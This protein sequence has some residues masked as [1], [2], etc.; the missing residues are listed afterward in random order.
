M[1][2]IINNDMYENTTYSMAQGKPVIYV[3]HNDAGSM[4]ARDYV[5]WLRSAR[6]PD[7][8]KAESGFAHYYVDRNT[9]ARVQNTT[10]VA[11]AMGNTWGNNNALSYEV[12]QQFSA[13]TKEFIENEN[14]VL[15]QMAEDMKFYGD[16]PNHSTIRLHNEYTSTSCPQRTKQLHGNNYETI[17][18]IIDKIKYYQKLGDTVA[19]MLE[20]EGSGVEVNAP[21]PKPAQAKKE[22]DSKETG[23]VLHLPASADRWKIYNANG[24]YTSGD[25]IHQLTPSAYG[26]LEYDVLGNPAPHV[27]LIETGVKGEV[28]IYAHPSTGAWLTGGN[29]PETQTKAVPDSKGGSY[30]HLPASADTWNIY[31]KGGPYTTGNEIHKLTPSAYGG[32]DYEIQGNPAPHVYLIDTDVKGRV[33]IYAHPSTGAT[34]SEN[35]GS[36][37]S[38]KSTAT[39]AQEVINGEWGSGNARKQNLESA[40]YD[41][42]AV[43]NK[44]NELL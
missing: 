21:E 32:L 3:L 16:E 6:T 7:T 42:D 30:L 10:Q 41:Y 14:M 28:A 23:K 29:A 5:S 4:S 36:S 15:R 44:V 11:W 33:A 9:I 24:P 13:S 18:Y 25:Q 35:S 27:Y 22:V 38:S 40:G 31:N 12:A 20:A 8:A 34:I 26:G 2:N 1:V 17:G 43:Q 19:D 37:S 39:L